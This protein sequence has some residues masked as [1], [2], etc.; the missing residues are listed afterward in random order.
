MEGWWEGSAGSYL[1]EAL[2]NEEAGRAC[3]DND[4]VKL[5]LVR[6]DLRCIGSV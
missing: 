5:F 4:C 6:H 1:F 3:P 2:G